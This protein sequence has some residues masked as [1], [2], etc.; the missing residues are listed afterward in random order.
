M[1]DRFVSEGS[2]NNGRLSLMRGGGGGERTQAGGY[3]QNTEKEN[4]YIHFLL[5]RSHSHVSLGDLTPC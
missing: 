2:L 1:S 4:I 3:E 5:C